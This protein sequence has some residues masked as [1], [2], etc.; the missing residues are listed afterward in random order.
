MEC[1]LPVD[2]R[3]WVGGR[4]G[5]CF[6]NPEIQDGI[7]QPSSVRGPQ[8]YSCY[9]WGDTADLWSHLGLECEGA[10]GEEERSYPRSYFRNDGCEAF[11]YVWL[12]LGL[13]NGRGYCLLTSC[14]WWVGCCWRAGIYYYTSCCWRTNCCWYSNVEYVVETYIGLYTRRIFEASNQWNYKTVR[15]CL[16]IYR[17][18]NSWKKE[19]TIINR[20]AK[21]TDSYRC[22]KRLWKTNWTNTHCPQ[23]L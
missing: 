10:A 20:V 2:V 7:Q 23:R 18:S 17:L 4:N 5:Y 3:T 16:V 12:A 15:Q 1:R 14:Y 19:W 21:E 11:L 9:L 6:C 22:S 13:F 8:G